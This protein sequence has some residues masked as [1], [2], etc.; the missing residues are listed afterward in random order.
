MFRIKVTRSLSAEN[1]E[2]YRPPEIHTASNYLTVLFQSDFSVAADGWKMNWA[3]DNS[4]CGNQ[5]FHQTDGEIK[6]LVIEQKKLLVF[7]NLSIT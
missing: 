2:G 6:E 3:A 1:P 7:E 4:G 5:V